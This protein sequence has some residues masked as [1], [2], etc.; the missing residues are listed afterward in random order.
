MIPKLLPL[1]ALMA[2]AVA[3]SAALISST[4]AQQNQSGNNYSSSS[5]I[6]DS[7]ISGFATR[8]TPGNIT[9]TTAAENITLT[10]AK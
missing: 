8:T 10:P 2:V 3:L 9:N 6:T 5:K 4:Y 1:F 7:N